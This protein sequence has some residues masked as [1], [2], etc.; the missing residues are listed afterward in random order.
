MIFSVILNMLRTYLEKR[1]GLAASQNGSG[2]EVLNEL[3]SEVRIM[4]EYSSN[5]SKMMK[6]AGVLDDLGN[7]V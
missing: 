3:A 1:S 5:H 2:L 6:L 4:A 7:G